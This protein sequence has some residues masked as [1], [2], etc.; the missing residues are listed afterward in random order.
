MNSLY[1]GDCLDVLR[2]HIP[3][4]SVDLIYLDPPF[5]S[6]RKYNL[7]FRQKSGGE[8][9]AQIEAFDDSWTW[10]QEAERQYQELLDG[11]APTTLADTLEGL[12]R[13]LGQS[14]AM[15]YLVMMSARLVELHRVLKRTG[16]LYLHCDPTASHYLKIVLDAL[17]GIDLFG[18]EIIWKYK[19]GGRSKEHFGRKHDT[20]FR[21]TKSKNFVFNS[22]NP[23]V[24]IPH[25]EDSLRVNYRH[26]DQ[27]G[28]RKQFSVNLL[29]GVSVPQ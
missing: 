20:I 4:D 22:D 11:G 24:R 7:L 25:E 17:F 13:L 6:D 23:A 28:Y 18:N 16:T 9:Q 2:K 27:E 26:I 5:N 3:D 8:S 10:T 29:T 14:D 1:Y 19:Y 15:A 12:R 21:Y